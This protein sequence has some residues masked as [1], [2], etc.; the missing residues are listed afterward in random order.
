MNQR[1]PSL[2]IRLPK[3]HGVKWH[4]ADIIE[5]IDNLDY[6]IVED[7][8][9]NKNNL[10]EQYAVVHFDRWFRGAEEVVT[11]LLRG[12]R[13]DVPGL[14]GKSVSVNLYRPSSQQSRSYVRDP[15]MN[16]YKKEH[17]MIASRVHESLPIVNNAVYVQTIAGK[18]PIAPGLTFGHLIRTSNNRMESLTYAVQANA[19][20]ANAEDGELVDSR[21]STHR[22]PPVSRR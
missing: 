9:I 2:F 10:G 6:G 8:S 17:A 7:V 20:Q 18:L 16:R 3:L 19:V 13:F 5:V 14:Y 15:R 12:E 4:E 1:N 21:F 22:R 11:D